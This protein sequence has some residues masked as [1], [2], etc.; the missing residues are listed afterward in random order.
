MSSFFSL[1][2]PTDDSEAI[3]ALSGDFDN[4]G[5]PPVTPQPLAKVERTLLQKGANV[6]LPPCYI[7]F[8]KLL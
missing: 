4:S 2:K 8:P 5:K 6:D 7:L 1:Q 3:D